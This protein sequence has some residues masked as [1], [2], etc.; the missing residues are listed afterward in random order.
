[1]IN[2]RRFWSGFIYFLCVLALV[3]QRILFNSGVFSAFTGQSYSAAW[4]LISQTVCMG[5]IPFFGFVLYSRSQKKGDPFL[6]TVKSFGYSKLPSKENMLRTLLV[7][8]LM[9]FTAT[10]VSVVWNSVL[11]AM[12]FVASQSTQTEYTSVGVL[13][14]EI[15]LVA[16]FPAIFE[17]LTHRGLLFAGFG[18]KEYGVKIVFLSAILFSLMHQN[19]RQTGYTFYDGIILGLLVYYSGSIYPAMFAHFFNN[20]ISV[21]MEY[22][23]Q[24]G[25]ALNVMNVMSSLLTSSAIG[26]AVYFVLFLLSLYFLYEIF[27][28]MRKDSL[29]KYPIQLFDVVIYVDRTF[30]LQRDIFGKKPR[31]ITWRDDV[32]LYCAVF[33]GVAL[34]TFSFVWGMLR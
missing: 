24:K 7:A 31:K 27:K 6:N 10:F 23:A 32:F 12:G 19:I 15:A 5:L 20:L 22:G 9:I 8:V 17:D 34:T 26:L 33:L 3:V 30:D 4:T 16:V 2:K 21:L 18:T 11:S 25:G 1:M 28:G 13:F 29:K 14:A